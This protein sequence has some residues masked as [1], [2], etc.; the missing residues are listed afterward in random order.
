MEASS[1]PHLALLPTPPIRVLVLG[2]GYGGVIAANRIAGKLGPIGR[3]TLVSDRDD[4]VNRIRLH[5]ALA[6]R[7]YRPHAL[8]SVVSN[9]VQIVRGRALAVHA[10]AKRIVV[11]GLGELPYDYLVVT[12]GSRLAL[13]VPGAREHAGWLASPETAAAGAARLAA[14]PDGA[15]VV[16]IGGGLTAIEVASEIAEAHPRLR[17]TM[18]ASELAAGLSARGRAYVREVLDDLRVEVRD[19]RVEAI[20]DDAV[21][22]AGGERVPAAMAV[23]AAGF[24]PA[25]P[26][27]ETDL[28]RDRR[29]RLIVDADL[30]AHGDAAVFVAGDAAAPPPGMEFYR[31]AC[32]TALPTAAHAADGVAA[33]VAGDEPR[34][35]RFGYRFQCVS[36]GRRR[37]V[38]QRVDGRD[39]PLDTVYTGRL[40]A[41]VKELICRFVIGS[42]RLERRWAGTL[43]WPRDIEAGAPA[44]G[45]LPG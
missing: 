35:F 2:G 25:G 27:I 41:M 26:A 14:L 23:W 16:V 17:V 42:I 24:E 10:A 6:G 40:A 13:A 5:E 20:A 28:A 33:L 37:G 18:L 36:L 4:L 12:L 11:D 21:V 43:W 29:G 39:R 7:A 9:R 3:V 32:A 34:R 45:L 1:S 38:V 30:R 44:P 31:M 15:P 8:A 19:G 22:V